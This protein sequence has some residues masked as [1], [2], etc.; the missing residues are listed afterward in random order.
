MGFPRLPLTDDADLFRVL[1]DLGDEL[2][3]LHLMEL[4]AS[5]LPSFPIQGDN[6]VAECNYTEMG[7]EDGRG[8]IF[9]NSQQY[10]EGVSSEVWGF[11]VG[12]YQICKK[13]LKDRKGRTL[14]FEDLRH[15][16]RVVGALGETIRLMAAIDD[17]IEEHGG[18]PLMK[19]AASTI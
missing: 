4:I 18:W 14:S 1:C 12:G 3:G 16:Q 7:Q 9:I 8:R 5:N 13:W 6:I 19:A 15:Y 11:Q 10:F 17:A 2:V